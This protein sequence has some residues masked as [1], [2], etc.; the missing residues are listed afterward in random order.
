MHGGT[1]ILYGSQIIASSL[2]RW[3]GCCRRLRQRIGGTRSRVRRGSRTI[4][5]DRSNHPL[6]GLAL[7]SAEIAPL[8]RKSLI[9]EMAQVIGLPVRAYR[10][11]CTT[12]SSQNRFPD[13]VW[14]PISCCLLGVLNSP[15]LLPLRRTHKEP[16]GL[17]TSQKAGGINFAFAGRPAPQDPCCALVEK[18]VVGGWAAIP[19][20]ACATGV[21]GCSSLQGRSAVRPRSSH[22]GW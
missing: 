1:E 11:W 2:C 18:E 9:R 14:L 13:F 19:I 17:F 10:H 3:R 20:K 16:Q 6:L 5:R 4:L 7:W 22:W 15:L 12:T 21:G 8:P